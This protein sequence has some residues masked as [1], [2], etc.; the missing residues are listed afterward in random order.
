MILVNETNIVKIEEIIRKFLYLG[1]TF[2]CPRKIIFQTT[3]MK[4]NNNS[5]KKKANIT[6]KG[7]MLELL[8]KNDPKM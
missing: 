1:S 4:I 6:T 5:I 3:R 7:V 8:I 2:C